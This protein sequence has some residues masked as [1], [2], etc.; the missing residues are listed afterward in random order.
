[1]RAFA[2]GSLSN[3]ALVLASTT[4]PHPTFSSLPLFDVAAKRS[5]GCGSSSGTSSRPTA[6]TRRCGPRCARRWRRCARTEV[7]SSMSH[8]HWSPYDRVGVVNADP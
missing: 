6:A 4:S 3:L 1:V 7:R 5:S 8:L 2:L